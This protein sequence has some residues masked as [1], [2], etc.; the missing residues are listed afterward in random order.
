M[1]PRRLRPYAVWAPHALVGAAG[2]L[3]LLVSFASSGGDLNQALA[4]TVFSVGPILLTLVRPV[5]AF[6]FSWSR[7]RSSP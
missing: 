1:L 5:G 2:M 6:W 7:S 3:A 4:T